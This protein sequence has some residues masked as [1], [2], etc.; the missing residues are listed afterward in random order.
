M[1]VYFF[2]SFRHE[3]QYAKWHMNLIENW[4]THPHTHW[5][6]LLCYIHNDF[7][8]RCNLCCC[9]CIEKQRG[10]KKTRWIGSKKNV[11][12]LKYP[13]FSSLDY[14]PINIHRILL[15]HFI[16]LCFYL[17]FPL[18]NSQISRLLIEILLFC[19]PP[20]AIRFLKSN[21]QKLPLFP[22]VNLSPRIPSMQMKSHGWSYDHGLTWTKN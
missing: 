4:N 19:P 3:K 5:N 10:E 2:V 7:Y 14:F 16:I 13:C 12:I 8:F 20:S 6:Y 11:F 17:N 18:Q 9:Y 1:N 15:F 21:H 22:W